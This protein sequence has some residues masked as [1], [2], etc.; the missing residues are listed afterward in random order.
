[1]KKASSEGEMMEA[2]MGNL[3]DEFN[4]WMQAVQREL[5]EKSMRS[6]IIICPATLD[7]QLEKLIK[8]IVTRKE[9]G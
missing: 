5:E 6:T 3:V 2:P 7:A 1:M 4:M 9:Y 8:Y